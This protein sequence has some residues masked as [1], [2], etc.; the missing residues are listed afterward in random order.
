MRNRILAVAFLSALVAVACAA[1]PSPSAAPTGGPAASPARVFTVDLIERIGADASV[2]VTDESGTLVGAVSATPGDGASVPDGAIETASLSSDP[3]KIALTWSGS[4]C[5]T[6][7]AL[8]IAPDGLNMRL[9][10][11]RCD[12]D[13]IGVDHIL[14]LTFDHPV[15]VT[16]VNPVLRTI[17]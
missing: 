11:P 10:R 12:G 13:A 8:T 3:H 5:D 9:D 4:P 7:H 16:R 15:D 1:D 2:T 14:V 17:G 6:V